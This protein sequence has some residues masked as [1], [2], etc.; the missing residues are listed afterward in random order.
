MEFY[1]DQYGGTRIPEEAFPEFY[2]RAEDALARLERCYSIEGGEDAR[3]MAL[4]AMAEAIYDSTGK[5]GGVTAASVGSVS[6]RYADIDR[7]LYDRAA[8]YLEI[9]RGTAE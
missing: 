9:Y 4:C 3:R 8:T 7:S 2:R 1:R 6:V 5:R